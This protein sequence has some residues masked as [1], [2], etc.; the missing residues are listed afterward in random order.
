M[1]KRTT[2]R[3]IAELA[4][5]SPGTVYKI[6]HDKGN[7]SNR[8]KAAVDKVLAA[9]GYASDEY[10]AA[11]AKACRIAVLAPAYTIGDYWSRIYEGIKVAVKQ[12]G[13]PGVSLDFFYYNQFDVYSCL[14]A[15]RLLLEKKPDA[16]IVGTIF[17]E[18]TMNFC[19]SLE[20]ASIPYALVD[21]NLEGLHPLAI[22]AADQLSAGKAMAHL[23]TAST[24]PGSKLAVFESK[25]S[26]ARFSVNS[27][28][29]RDGFIDFLKAAGREKDLIETCY[30]STVPSENEEAIRRLLED[31]KE[32]EGIAVL[33]SRGSSIAEVLDKL[34]R[35][36]IKLIS[37]DMTMQNVEF[38]RK[39]NISALLCQ[40]PY[41][42][43]FEAASTLIRHQIQGKEP[44]SVLNLLSIDIVLKEIVDFYKDNGS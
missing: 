8:S 39:G 10:F 3:E 9:T 20:E 43:G 13:Y 17:L 7:V 11:T 31:H 42:Q 24:R 38:L 34:G 29:R 4:G 28:V 5:V 18:E 15:H 6:L 23:L 1:S 30:T 16:V 2:I 44:A 32:I 40:H 35:K 14:A 25:R 36:D 41:W 12:S 22:F 26:G 19:L 27:M 33:N 21:S 37:F